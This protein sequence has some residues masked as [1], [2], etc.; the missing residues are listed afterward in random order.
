MVTQLFG[1]EGAWIMGPIT[2][3]KYLPSLES[4]SLLDR[5]D[6]FTR[7]EQ[8]YDTGHSDLGID[9]T[10]LATGMVLE[11][12]RSFANSLTSSNLKGTSYV[13]LCHHEYLLF[14]DLRDH[15]GPG[16]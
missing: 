3:R 6:M 10:K 1:E 2:W 13:P 8:T 12:V 11:N 7:K 14:S 16:R 9:T 4:T 15:W 5:S